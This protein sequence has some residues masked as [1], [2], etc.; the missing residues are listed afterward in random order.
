MAPETLTNFTYAD[1][2]EMPDDGRH[3]EIIDGELIVNASPIP[4]HQI[5]ALRLASWIFSFL[6]ANPL[7]IVM[8]APLDVVFTQRWV[9]Q[10]DILY[11]R[12]ERKQIIGRTNVSGAPD[13]AVEVLSD[14]TRRNDEVLKRR[15]YED[16]GVSEYW[17]VDPVIE[18]VKIFRRNAAGKYERVAELTNE[19]ENA[20][21]ESPLFPGL[22]IKLARVFAE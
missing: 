18:S 1:L 10:P 16:F 14:S 17:I 3:Y 20:S 5:I 11:V 6:E 7:G 15:A 9:L 21:L 2:L 8:T 22:T 4:R 19:T 13:L 12:N